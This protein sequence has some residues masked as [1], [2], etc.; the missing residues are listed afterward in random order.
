MFGVKRV[1]M[2]MGNGWWAFRTFEWR[3]FL[4][5]VIADKGKFTP[6]YIRRI[7]LKPT[8]IQL[9]DGKWTSSKPGHYVVDV[10]N[11]TL[12]D[13]EAELGLFNPHNLERVT[14]GLIK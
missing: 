6:P 1:Y 2:K 13:F 8:F 10:E 12:G 14:K 3:G 7:M 4:R 5:E 9:Q 11:W